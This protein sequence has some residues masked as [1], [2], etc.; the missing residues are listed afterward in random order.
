[1]IDS[2]IYR[3]NILGWRNAITARPNPGQVPRMCF[4]KPLSK[5]NA[6]QELCFMIS[7]TKVDTVVL[8]ATS[9]DSWVPPP[10]SLRIRPHDNMCSRCTCPQDLRERPMLTTSRDHP[11]QL[12][13]RLSHSLQNS[14]E[15]ASNIRSGEDFHANTGPT[16]LTQ[17]VRATSNSLSNNA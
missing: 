3:R 6:P 2:P 13:E 5:P 8:V 4:A 1:M 17:S 10:R 7:E 15:V 16:R 11:V 9:K 12:S 14:A